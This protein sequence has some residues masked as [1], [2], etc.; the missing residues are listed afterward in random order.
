MTQ[1][2]IEA[3]KHISAMTTKCWESEHSGNRKQAIVLLKAKLFQHSALGVDSGTIY[4]ELGSGVAEMSRSKQE[5]D[6]ERK[7]E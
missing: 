1:V 2:F 3:L 7:G 4:S 6:R 5:A